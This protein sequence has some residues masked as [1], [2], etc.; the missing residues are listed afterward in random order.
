MKAAGRHQG[1]WM[2]EILGSVLSS[3]SSPLSEP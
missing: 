1:V 3:V 2:K